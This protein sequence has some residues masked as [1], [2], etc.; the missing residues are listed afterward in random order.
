[1][2][3]W[4]GRRG[5]ALYGYPI[6]LLQMQQVNKEFG[7]VLT[8]YRFMV[9]QTVEYKQSLRHVK[10]T[11][12]GYFVGLLYRSRSGNTGIG[13]MFLNKMTLTPSVPTISLF[14]VILSVRHCF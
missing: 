6:L 2:W 11:K 12:Q 13:S 14:Y 8:E 10:E 4:E 1:M 7:P 9:G 5:L 3:N